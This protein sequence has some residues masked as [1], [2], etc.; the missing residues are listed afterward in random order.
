LISGKTLLAKAIANECQANFISIKI[1]EVLNI[2]LGEAEANIRDVFDKARQ[3]APC[4]LF[5][6]ELHLIGKTKRKLMKRTFVFFLFK[7]SDTSVGCHGSLVNRV[8]TK[9]LVEIDKMDG[10]KN[11]FFVGASIRT[12][13]FN[14]PFHREGKYIYTV[15]AHQHHQGHQ[16]RSLKKNWGSNKNLLRPLVALAFFVYYGK[17][18]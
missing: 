14:S 17:T 13:I 11:V 18:I 15:A 3:A 8:F 1:S 4:I 5:I 10:N 7:A 2:W 9:I 12:D 16:L 6:D